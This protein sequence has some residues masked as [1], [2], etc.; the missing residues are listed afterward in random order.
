M[1]MLC[2]P[3]LTI[4]YRVPL[5][6]QLMERCGAIRPADRPSISFICGS[7]RSIVKRVEQAEAHHP[8]G[9][10]ALSAPRS[11]R[12]R[13]GV[14]EDDLSSEPG[15]SVHQS[16][17]GSVSADGETESCES[18][19][20]DHEDEANDAGSGFQCPNCSDRYQSQLRTVD[21][22]EKAACAPSTHSLHFSRLF[23]LYRSQPCRICPSTPAATS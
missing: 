8:A 7:L 3:V 5:S 19:G 10:H 15:G 1:M 21:H 23:A 6:L 20:D 17:S 12:I 18:D 11:R 16:R 2:V 14:E 4:S 9:A 13:V 22:G